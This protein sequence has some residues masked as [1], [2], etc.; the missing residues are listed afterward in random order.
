MYKLP[1]LQMLFKI[2]RLFFVRAIRT[3]GYILL[4]IPY[5]LVAI[6]VFGEKEGYLDNAFSLLAK[7]I[8]KDSVQDL[9][10]EDIVVAISLL[11]IVLGI[12]VELIFK[13][14]KRK[15]S[16]QFM[17]RARQVLLICGYM[18]LGMTLLLRDSSYTNL[19]DVSIL[20]GVLLT[21]SLALLLAEKLVRI[22]FN[23]SHNL[24]TRLKN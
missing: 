17:Y 11:S 3:P 8:G 20:C 9:G 23:N 6:L 22:A 18:L 21:V 19:L 1:V 5:L 16:L 7:F 15:N 2:I 4:T 14:I 13:M 12:A 24:K 10:F